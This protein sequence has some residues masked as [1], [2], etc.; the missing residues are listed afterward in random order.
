MRKTY[1]IFL[2]F[3]IGISACTKAIIDESAVAP[4]PIDRIITYK[5]DVQ[6][7]MFNHCITC[8]SGA[9]P[10]ADLDLSNY[11]NVRFS[12]ESGNLLQRIHNTENPMP[13][14]GLLS[15]ENQQILDKWFTDGFLEE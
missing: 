2:F 4:N 8:H 11:D 14:S 13:P 5:S 12:A 6:I 9:A 3:I 1:F 7:I 15:A 10:L